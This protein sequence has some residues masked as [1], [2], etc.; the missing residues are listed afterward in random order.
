M[1]EPRRRLVE[2]GHR[3]NPV[4]PVHVW[5]T[6]PGAGVT[7]TVVTDV[8]VLA[9]VHA[10]AVAALPNETGGFLLGRVAHE[11]E[12][13][14]WYIQVQHAETLVPTTQ[15]PGHFSFTWREVDSVRDRREAEG[16]AIVGWF[17]SHPGFGVFLSE[18][19]VTRTHRVL[20]SEPFQVALVY[21]P[22]RQRAGY[23]FWEQGHALD[24]SEQPWREFD[25]AVAD[26][27]AGSVPLPVVEADRVGAKADPQQSVGAS[28]QVGEAARSRARFPQ[29]FWYGLVLGGAAATT[30]WLLAR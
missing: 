27:P 17:H 29:A 18:T 23:F 24:P 3:V 6:P 11:A 14:G 16:L 25:V 4:I 20:F 10:H 7:L 21:D 8:D 15:S 26:S 13:G 30:V 19:D 28:A 12:T 1:G 5:R 2:E 9:R 22:V